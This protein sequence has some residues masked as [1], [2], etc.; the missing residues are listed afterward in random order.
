MKR[1]ARRPAR[2]PGSGSRV[3]L[4]SSV[5]EK[6][7]CLPNGSAASRDE[8]GSPTGA[9]VFCGPDPGLSLST[10][11]EGED[12]RDG[13]GDGLISVASNYGKAL[14]VPCSASLNPVR[15][16]GALGGRVRRVPQGLREPPASSR[17]DTGRCPTA[18]RERQR[19]ETPVGLSQPTA[20]MVRTHVALAA[21]FEPSG[22]S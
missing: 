20:Q 7:G 19:S 9:A 11:R 8:R 2:K 6:V 21:T 4:G 1:D 18:D 12:R 14:R 5:F 17:R 10:G 22:E 3:K 16:A 15:T 13:A